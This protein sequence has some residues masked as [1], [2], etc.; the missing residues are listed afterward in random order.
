MFPNPGSLM[1]SGHRVLKLAVLAAAVSAGTV[2]NAT[3]LYRET[4]PF[5]SQTAS[6]DAEFRAQGWEGGNAGDT[7]NSNPSGTAANNGGEGAISSSPAS[8]GPL[9]AGA[10]VNNNPQGV[11]PTDSFAFWSQRGVGADSFAYTTEYVFQSSAL[12]SVSW[13]AKDSATTAGLSDAQRLAFLIGGDWYISDQSWTNPNTTPWTNN[14]ATL[15][16]LTFFQ[17]AMAGNILPGGGVGAGGLSLP[18]GQVDAFGL[19]WDGPKVANSR[20]DNFTL[21]GR[22]AVPEPASLVLLGA[23]LAGA[24]FARRRRR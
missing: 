18:N 23:G 2:A 12:A 13:D 6:Q 22:T 20:F 8:Q 5:R 19:W 7:F 16:G 10:G 1:S 15:A 4:F 3:V 14:V 11:A 24:V 17:R 9:T 21:I